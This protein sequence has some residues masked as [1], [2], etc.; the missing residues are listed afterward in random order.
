M[1]WVPRS[2]EIEHKTDIKS[3][4]FELLARFE[5][6]AEAFFLSRIVTAG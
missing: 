4:S 6:K 2:L 5:A 3:V 1:R